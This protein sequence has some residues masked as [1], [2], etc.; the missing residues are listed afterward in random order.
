MDAVLVSHPDTYH[1]GAL[2]YLYGRLGL[3]CPVF[4]T[5]PVYRMGQM[6]IY[7][8]Y[9]VCVWGEGEGGEGKEGVG[10]RGSVSSRSS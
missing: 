3:R 5:V 1:L 6:F 2:P 8:L 10:G 9:Q 7:D 4:A